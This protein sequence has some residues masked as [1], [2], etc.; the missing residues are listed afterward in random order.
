M[1]T[2]C[3]VDRHICQGCSTEFGCTAQVRVSDSLVQKTKDSTIIYD[4]RGKMKV[5]YKEI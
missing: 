1:K 3:S 4:G 5:E 2:I